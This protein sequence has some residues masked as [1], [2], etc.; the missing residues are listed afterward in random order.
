MKTVTI[1][2]GNTDNKLTQEA[3]YNY[4]KDIEFIVLTTAVSLEFFGGPAGW[5]RWQNVAW[6]MITEESKLDDLREKLKVV[7]KTYLQDSIAIVVGE[8]EFI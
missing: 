8:T 3:W 1:L 4:V 6:V 5:E 2:I 7:G